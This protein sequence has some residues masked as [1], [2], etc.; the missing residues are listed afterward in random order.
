LDSWRI[1]AAE[2][3]L[4]LTEEGFARTFGRTAREVV[5]ELWPDRAADA[6][7]L[8]AR[9]EAC[10]RRLVGDHLPA[11]DGAA[12]LVRALHSAGWRLAVASSGPPENVELVVDGLGVRS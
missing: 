7:E 3:G 10:Y 1:V 4:S 6:A 11:A 5:A 8:D 2:E 9:K 12:E